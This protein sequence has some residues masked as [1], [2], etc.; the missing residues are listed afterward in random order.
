MAYTTNPYVGRTRRDAV[1]DVRFHRLTQVQA[2]LKYGVVRSTIW[3]WLQKA[4]VHNREFINTLPSRPK[5]HPKKLPEATITRIIELRT[6]LGRCAPVLHAHLKQEGFRVSLSSVE[7][8]LRRFDLT[9]KRKPAKYYTPLPRPVSAT[10]GALVQVDT[11]HYV[12]SNTTRFYIYAL[13]DVY[14]RLAY[15]EYHPKLSQRISLGVI[16]NAQKRFGFKFFMIQT[17]NGPEF[18]DY[19]DIQLRRNKISLRHSRV[20]TPNDNA[21]V[22][23]FNRT[24]QEECF[25]GRRPNEKT[26]RKLLEAYLHYYNHARLHLGINLQTPTSFVSKVLT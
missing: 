21:H 5:S 16:R 8:I 18:K 4:P 2:A 13:I 17:D 14:S 11:I 23:R 10:P 6:G 1:N 9:R 12:R 25:N 19:L 7:R 26:A 24:L 22:E 15:A 3:K 20:R